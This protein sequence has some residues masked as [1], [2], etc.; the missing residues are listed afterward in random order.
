LSDLTIPKVEEISPLEEY[1]QKSVKEMVQDFYKEKKVQENL[2]K[3]NKL[4]SSHVDGLEK[5]KDIIAAE[6]DHLLSLI[7][8][9]LGGSVQDPA[10]LASVQQ[11]LESVYVLQS[12]QD[13]CRS[14]YGWDIQFLHAHEDFLACLNTFELQSNSGASLL[15]SRNIRDVLVSLANV[16]DTISLAWDISQHFCL[17]PQ[18]NPASYFMNFLETFVDRDSGLINVLKL[19]SKAMLLPVKNQIMSNLEGFFVLPETEDWHV[20]VKTEFP[21][22]IRVTHRQAVALENSWF[23]DLV[24]QWKV[25]FVVDPDL[26]T[27]VSVY[28]AVLDEHHK[29]KNSAV[30][31]EDQEKVL[32]IISKLFSLS[33]TLADRKKMAARMKRIRAKVDRRRGTV[34]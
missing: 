29:L 11:Q 28:T 30:P 34:V 6:K 21:L 20:T 4:I 32:K 24:L 5:E 13:D 7:G 16:F 3:Y 12:V 14:I 25:E 1:A 33:L 2:E 15:T 10:L 18:D 26:L 19:C 17:T 27:I 8:G 9:V 22:N 23:G 31:L